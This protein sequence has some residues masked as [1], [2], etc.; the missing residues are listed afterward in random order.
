VT[1]PT[2]AALRGVKVTLT[3]EAT[4]QARAAVTD[5][6][7]AY[8]FNELRPSSYTIHIEATGFRATDRTHIQLATQDFLTLDLSLAVGA[9]PDVAQVS[10]E[11]SLVDPS[12]ASVSTDLSEEQLVTLPILGR[13]PYMTVKVSG[14]FV[15]TGNPQFVRFADQNGTTQTSVAGGP[16]GSNQYLV[17]GVPITDTNNRPI[18][19]PTIESIQDVKV[20]ANTYDAQVGRTGGAVFN[21]L[22]RS[23]SSTYHGSVFGATRRPTGWPTISLPTARGFRGPTAR[24]TTGAHLWVDLSRS[25][26]S[27][28]AATR[29]SS[30]S[31]RKATSRP[32]RTLRHLLCPRRW[33]AT[34][35]S[36]RAI[37]RMVHL[38][39]STTPPRPIPIPMGS[40]IAHHS[41]AM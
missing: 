36:P 11:A 2:G 28:T 12:T 39:L 13:N 4:R 33:S 17:D 40:F 21:T 1:D 19:I 29:R 14:L 15:N 20:Q 37:T 27:T 8:A 25:L 3:D 35:I 38:M 41:P 7:G 16:V 32:R 30:L 18:V 5:P 10:A 22:L 26:T 9:E 23:G 34:G 6:I 24:I 31:D